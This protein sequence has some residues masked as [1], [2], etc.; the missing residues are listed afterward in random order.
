M[1]EI[2]DSISIEA[3]R[4]L[5]TGP[6]PLPGLDRMPA[7]DFGDRFGGASDF[8]Y[9]ICLLIQKSASGVNIAQLLTAA[10]HLLELAQSN[11]EESAD[12]LD[13]EDP[14]AE[15]ISAQELEFLRGMVR[16]HA[17][18]IRDAIRAA[19]SVSTLVTCALNHK[20]A[21]NLAR[22]LG[23]KAAMTSAELASHVLISDELIQ[24][25]ETDRDG[26]TEFMKTQL[27]GK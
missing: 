23:N 18:A 5:I 27:Q 6:K 1:S 14:R 15:G 9:A 12:H 25:L 2:P 13:P 24:S 11:L 7:L 8:Q 20:R 19:D 3:L 21:E 16:S 10:I 17:A 26:I 4:N 22:A